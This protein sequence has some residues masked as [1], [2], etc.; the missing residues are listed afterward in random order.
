MAGIPVDAELIRGSRI[1][2]A[3]FKLPAKQ[4][5]DVRKFENSADDFVGEGRASNVR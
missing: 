1:F 5:P 2:D 4:A 3:P